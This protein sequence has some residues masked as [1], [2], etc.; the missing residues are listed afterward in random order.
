M[1]NYLFE[2]NSFFYIDNVCLCQGLLVCPLS[3]ENSTNTI[4]YGILRRAH[5]TRPNGVFLHNPQEDL[6]TVTKS[7]SRRDTASRPLRFAMAFSLLT[8]STIEANTAG[9][10]MDTTLYCTPNQNQVG[11]YVLD[12]NNLGGVIAKNGF[13]DFW[14]TLHSCAV[15]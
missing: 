1:P 9:S 5:P 3:P 4:L 7:I 6:W 12:R 13:A 15:G 2:R 8:V 14:I 10:L 11:K